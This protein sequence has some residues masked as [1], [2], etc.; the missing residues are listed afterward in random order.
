MGYSWTRGCPVGRSSLR[1]VTVNF[2]GFDGRRA[3]GAIVVNVRIATRTRAAFTALYQQGF[4][5]R[6]MKVMDRGWGRSPAGKGP[7]ANDYA[8]M[9]ADNTSAFNCRYVGGEESSKRWSNHAYGNAIDINTFEN[10]YL[11][12]GGRVYPHPWFAHRRSRH[13][14]VFSSRSSASV[15]AFTSRGF[16]W[17]GT[18]SAPDF[19]HFDVRR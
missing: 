14:G 3:R 18:W 5:I 9:R 7:G 8:A 19:Q 6:Q 1:Y 11:A 10:P 13:A 16:Q 12:P 15:R 2:W 4:R 17:G